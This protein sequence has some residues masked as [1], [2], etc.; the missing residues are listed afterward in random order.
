MPPVFADDQLAAYMAQA[1]PPGPLDVAA[2]RAGTE[3]RARARPPGPDMTAV[4]DLRAGG[5]A[6]RLYQPLAE[7]AG[8]V[9]GKVAVCG[10]S[11]GGTLAAL[12]CLR[13]RDEDSSALPVLQ[14]LLCANTDL[15]GSQP[16]MRDKGTGF[17]LEASG[18][19]FFNSQWVS[20]ACAAGTDRI[21]A[22]LR[23]RLA[24]PVTR[25]GSP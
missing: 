16:S 19:R 12:A 23:R 21:A 18:I 7:P 5:L 13:L 2:M 22:D 24:L 6:V 1:A 9:A 14:V 25:P 17:G 8:L 20:P 15:T 3:E 10:D 4:R 11:A